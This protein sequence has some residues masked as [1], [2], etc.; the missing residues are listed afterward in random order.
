RDVRT[1]TSRRWEGSVQFESKRSR[2]S[3][4]LARYVFRRVTVSSLNVSADQIPLLSQ[5]VL[6]GLAGLTWIRDTRDVPINARQGMFNTADVAV[7]ARQFGSQA[8]FV[9][10]LVQSSSYHRIGLRYVFARSTQLAVENPF[11]KDRMV[12]VNGQQVSTR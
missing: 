11:G 7:A 4:L 12:T 1:F 8:S 10:A 9:R 2:T 3:T 5:A 6:V